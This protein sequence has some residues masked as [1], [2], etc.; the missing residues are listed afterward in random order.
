MSN[1]FSMAEARRIKHMVT[2]ATLPSVARVLI[3]IVDRF[4]ER[5]ADISG[6][7]HALDV[8][9]QKLERREYNK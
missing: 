9:L 5:D 4:R 7:L 2:G 6:E 3:T 8:R 1:I